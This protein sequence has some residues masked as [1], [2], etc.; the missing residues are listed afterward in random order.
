MKVTLKD[1]AEDTGLSISTVSRALS[2]T[3]TISS[4]NEQKIFQSAQKLNYPLSNMDTPARLRKSIYVALITRF[5]PGEFYASFFDGFDNA[6]KNS[7]VNFG[8]FSLAN[9]KESDLEMILSLK[10]NL[11]DAAVIFLPSLTVNDYVEIIEK[12]GMDFPMISAAPMAT[13]IMD[14]VAFDNYRGG[15]LVARHFHEQ[16][17]KRLG[18]ILGPSD[19]ME[20]QLRRNGLTDYAENN[21]MEIVWEYPTN[22][23]LTEGQAAYDNFKVSKHKPE[24][25]FCLNDALAVGF[26]QRA[27]KDGIKIPR[28]VAVASYDDLPICQYH[29]PTITS[30]HPDYTTLGQ[31]ILKLLM[32]RME[33]GAD[34]THTGFTRL[35]PVTLNVRESSVKTG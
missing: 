6:S 5:H 17:Y 24:A 35:V 14:T 23:D 11:F 9:R 13:P 10:N 26:M 33:L 28:D 31:N 3:G 32:D 4:K 2:R 25:I 16:G 20:A 30:V 29:H 8:L 15:H 34:T 21:G 22:Y 12:V 19:K 1:I 18:I 7:N 27:F